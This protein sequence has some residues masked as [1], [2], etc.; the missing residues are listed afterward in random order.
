MFP[1]AM[2]ETSLSLLRAG[3]SMLARLAAETPRMAFID[4]AEMIPTGS[5]WPAQKGRLRLSDGHF[6]PA[7]NAWYA[8]LILPRLRALIVPNL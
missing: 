7:G 1:T 3:R 6:N 5:E 4:T 2:N 8:N